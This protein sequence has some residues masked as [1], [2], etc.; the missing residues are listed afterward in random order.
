MEFKPLNDWVLTEKIH[1]HTVTNSSLI[2]VPGENQAY[3]YK[4][5]KIV[6]IP[7]GG[8]KKDG[9]YTE[10]QYKVGDIVY[11]E[12]AAGLTQEF[13]DKEYLLVRDSD[14]IA[15]YEDYQKP[16]PKAALSNIQPKSVTSSNKH[17]F[18]FKPEY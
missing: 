4:D 18:L 6:S 1:Y 12:K 2:Y 8:I 16:N 14:I 9:K 17:Q 7:E 11:V 5:V 3:V 13:G 15:V 10:P